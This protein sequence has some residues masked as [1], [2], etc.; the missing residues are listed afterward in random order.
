[1]RKTGICYR[2]V[3]E[4]TAKENAGCLRQ[5]GFDCVFTGYPNAEKIT[6]LAD[7]FAGAGLIFESIHA[8]FDGINSIW[9][10]G[11]DGEIMLGRMLDCLDTCKKCGVP[12]MVVHLSSGE[13]APCITDLGHSRWDRLVDAAVGSGVSIAFENQ[14]KLANIAFVMELYRDVPEVGF[15]WDCGHEKCFTPGIEYMPLF[16]KRLIYTH[17]HDNFGVGEVTAEE[18]HGGDIHYMPFDG[19]TDFT[20]FA[21]LIKEFD[22]KGSLTLELRSAEKP[23]YSE[24]YTVRE[25]YARAYEAVSKLVKMCDGE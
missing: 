11:E 13:N 1:M 15:C 20:R 9:L 23:P 4:M 22:Y 12:V 5:L 3:K 19:N 21:S 2:N 16:G 6:G 14:R 17:I 24:K 18:K 8:P 7:V 25:F 10:P